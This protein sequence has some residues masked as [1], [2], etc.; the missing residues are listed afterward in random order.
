[1]SKYL[2][3][4]STNELNRIELLLIEHQSFGIVHNRIHNKILSIE[5]NRAFDY[6]TPLIFLVSILPSKL[7]LILE[8][9]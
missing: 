5:F 8:K 9:T 6:R 3:E 4:R 2:I 7:V 1:M